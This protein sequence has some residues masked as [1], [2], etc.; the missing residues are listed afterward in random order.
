MATNRQRF[1]LIIN[2]RRI[3]L[4]AGVESFPATI[5]HGGMAAAPWAYVILDHQDIIRPTT[6]PAAGMSVPVALPNGQVVTVH[7]GPARN[8]YVSLEF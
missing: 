3:M 4:D 8:H 1:P 7:F 2:G 6:V 5:A